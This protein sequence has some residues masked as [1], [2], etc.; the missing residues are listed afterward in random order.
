MDINDFRKGQGNG[1]EVKRDQ[2]G[3]NGVKRAPA[4]PPQFDQLKF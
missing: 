2:E 1:Q 4:S 3:S